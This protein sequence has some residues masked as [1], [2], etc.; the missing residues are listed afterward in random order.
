LIE[1]A[2]QI[3]NESARE[4]GSIAYMAR[5]LVQVTMPHSKPDSDRYIR[6]NGGFTVQML[7]GDA[8]LGLPYGATPRLV[9]AWMTTEAVKTKTPQLQL[10]VSFSDFLH[11]VGI[12]QPGV[13]SSGG[14]RG[15]RT[16]AQRQTMALFNAIVS[17]NYADDRAYRGSNIPIASNYNLAWDPLHADQ[18]TLWKSTVTMGD[19]FF[20]EVTSRPVPVDFRA[21]RAFKRSP[22]RL[23]IY[24]WLTYRMS[25]LKAATTVPWE[26]LQGQLG[27]GYPATKMGLR[28]FRKAFLE[29]LEAVRLVYNQARVEPSDAGLV[30]KPSPTHILRT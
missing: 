6:A 18:E 7:A 22:M 11:E 13:N 5:L 30:L 8:K 15:V 2:T 28:D 25:Y 3:E 17:W 4:A 16:Y 19:A 1:E 9:L 20:Q 21:L 12:I 26:Y 14:K 27:A 23:D 29:H 24:M 10:G